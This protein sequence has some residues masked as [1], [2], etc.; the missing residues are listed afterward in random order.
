MKIIIREYARAILASLAVISVLIFCLHG[1][2]GTD[3]EKG[4]FSLLLTCASNAGRTFRL[5]EDRE[6][7]HSVIQRDPPT[8][9]Y[10][11]AEVCAGKAAAWENLFLAWDAD[12]RQ[13]AVRAVSVDE[14]QIDS[15]S[16]VFLRGGIYEILICAKD[17]YG[18][19]AWRKFRIPVQGGGNT[20]GS[21]GDKEGG[22]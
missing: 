21:A 11:G 17:I 19:S 22:L 20:Q 8:I 14:E 3:G 4:M 9:V 1:L 2:A 13:T 5:Y 12:G 18:V 7:Y 15:P 10:S 6:I 16:Y